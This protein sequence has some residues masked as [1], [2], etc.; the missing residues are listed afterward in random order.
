M[1]LSLRKPR[2]ELIRQKV[3][4]PYKIQEGSYVKRPLATGKATDMARK[5]V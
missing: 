3:E 1:K 2:L 5:M 4:S